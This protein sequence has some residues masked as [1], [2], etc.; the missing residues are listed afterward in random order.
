MKNPL[1]REL[2]EYK[3]GL[4]NTTILHYCALVQTSVR[5]LNTESVRHSYL[6]GLVRTIAHT[7][8]EIYYREGRFP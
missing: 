5:R 3:Q 2:V 1:C 7:Q 8:R 4:G 6:Y